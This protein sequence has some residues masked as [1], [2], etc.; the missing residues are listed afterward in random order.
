MDVSF[1]QAG[2]YQASLPCGGHVSAD[3]TDYDFP[4]A[5]LPTFGHGGAQPL[6]A[7]ADDYSLDFGDGRSGGGISQ[8]FDQQDFLS[9]KPLSLEGDWFHDNDDVVR[10]MSL[11]SA[12]PL[13]PIP[14]L[15][16]HYDD[17]QMG[18][19][20]DFYGA[21]DYDVAR[22]Q[23]FADADDADMGHV[24]F[25]NAKK[26]PEPE[27]EPEEVRFEEFFPAP[28][29]PTDPEFR[30]E[31][32]NTIRI[33]GV[34]P[35][36]AANCVLDALRS[37][38]GVAI[39]K[40]RPH[41]FALKAA[42]CLGGGLS[43]EFKVFFY[44][45]ASDG[46]S[47]NCEVSPSWNNGPNLEQLEALVE[48][49]RRGGDCVALSKIVRGLRA[50][51]APGGGGGGG[52]QEDASP[53]PLPATDGPIGGGPSAL[54]LAAAPGA[55][56]SFCAGAGSEDEATAKP[57]APLI[58]SMTRCND[59]S[60][61]QA[62]LASTLQATVEEDLDSAQQ[63]C[64][65]EARVGFESLLGDGAFC[66]A[67]PAARSLCALARRPEIADLLLDAGLPQLTRLVLA[68]LEERATVRAIKEQLALSLCRLAQ[69][70]R[71][72]LAGGACRE[73]VAAVG[74]L[75]HAPSLAGRAQVQTR[76]WLKE[77]L[78]TLTA[79]MTMAG[80]PEPAKGLQFGSRRGVVQRDGAHWPC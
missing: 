29:E 57:Y 62:E 79:G 71:E 60:E 21:D 76:S 73:L 38:G 68:K 58:D 67:Y 27:P 48:F 70:C 31:D 1:R 63:F 40:V 5:P 24:H 11:G 9:G 17:W 7:F 64:T 52:A 3:G 75:L 65:V 13:A 20:G 28:R 49:Q 66:V 69:H 50:K 10:G 77:A 61:M 32:A 30:F 26:S 8:A 80:I 55:V 14:S 43:C 54:T 19:P 36:E 25:P 41:K 37:R 59:S 53:P 51:L 44:A 74:N 33:R 22:G 72:W 47:G 35:A 16:D 46:C 12:V 6:P 4:G 18:T 56:A 34:S 2:D 23:I 39:L 15:G 42:A 78:T 45:A